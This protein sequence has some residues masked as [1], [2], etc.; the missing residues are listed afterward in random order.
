MIVFNC[1]LAFNCHALVADSVL[2]KIANLNDDT[3]KVK[4]YFNIAKQFVQQ[5]DTSMFYANKSLLLANKLNFTIGKSDIYNLMG[6]MYW[7]QSDYKNAINYYQKSVELLKEGLNDNEI[8]NCYANI[9]L[10]YMMLSDYN[11][12]LENYQ[13]A[14]D[15]R[16]KINNQKAILRLLLNIGNAYY[17]K[18]DYDLA[19]NSFIQSA[20]IAEQFNDSV[21][22]SGAFNNIGNIYFDMEKLDKADE[23]FRKSLKI[24]ILLNDTSGM[25]Y[26][27][28]NLGN[29]QLKQKN[30]T[31]AIIFYNK[32]LA[33]EKKGNNKSNVAETYQSLGNVYN[34]IGKKQMAIDYYSKALFINN[35]IGN[36]NGKTY[37]L[38]SLAKILFDQ[39]NLNESLKKAT[40]AYDLTFETGSI[41]NRV[42]ALSL[43]SK[44]EKT[45]GNFKE[46]LKH[47]EQFKQINDSLINVEK[48]SNITELQTKYETE[49]KDREI[50]ILQKD[51]EIKTLTI[52]EQTQRVKVQRMSILLL[53]FGVIVVAVFV[54]VYL[55]LMKTR[56]ILIKN[57]LEIRNLQTEQ[58]MLR[59]QMN[60]HFI[61]NSLNS[62]Q[63]FI[64]SNQNYEAERYLARFAKLM[65]GILENSRHE[66]VL[67]DNEIEILTLYLEL[68]Q[69]RFDN[70]FSF[71]FNIDSSIDTEFIS[72]PPML[73]QPFIE[74]AVK[75]GIKGVQN[76]IINIGFKMEN[77]ILIC[78]VTD[79]G[80]G[81]KASQINKTNSGH[82]SLGLEI[83]RERMEILEKQSGMKAGFYIID[84]YDEQNNK[85]VGTKVEVVMP[86]AEI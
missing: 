10:G 46:S 82:H 50:E 41:P 51:N 26:S 23:Y 76:G 63:S 54:L 69:L 14:L 59:S 6:V 37:N 45:K 3:N 18:G 73:I 33:I 29:V 1:V 55:R 60:P 78:T 77:D 19:V 49:K 43:L 25:A 53:L 28:G 21:T 83:T 84:L 40:Q 4:A 86:F 34:E 12:A 74:N 56:N 58:K 68:E 52:D 9:G 11:N 48:Y 42:D 32:L 15:L 38:I 75:H 2:Q 13:I 80:V 71:V 8:S 30:Y 24:D 31:E 67:F 17:Y 66:F 47:F 16:K 64:S 70:S 61:Y 36:K 27:Y 20:Q 44:I 65:R 62:V 79:N 35:E 72:I 7:Y 39:K 85:A 81:R 5:F 22:L 57:G